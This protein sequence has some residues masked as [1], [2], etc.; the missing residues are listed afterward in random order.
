MILKPV[1]PDLTAYPDEFKT[2]LSNAMIFDS[3][4]SSN[5]RV[6]FIDKDGGYF[7]KSAEKGMLEN[8]VKMTRYF[9]NKGLSTNVISYVSRENDWL[10]TEKINGDDCIAAKYLDQPERLCDILAELLVRLHSTDFAGCPVKNHT[11]QYIARASNNYFSSNFDKSLFP[12]NWGYRSVDEA[13]QAV[14]KNKHLL[15]TDT[16]LHG[17]Y[18]LPNIILNDWKFGGFI[19]LVGSGVGDRHVDIFWAIWS[20]SFN[21]KTNIYRERFIDAYGRCNIDEDLLRVVAAIE[22]FG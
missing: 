7:L 20:L 3:S 2:M 4:C 19:D 16:L 15:K 21:L 13:W 17:D 5:A 18:C 22:V 11:N 9:H 14:E 1:I 8:E 12:D 6:I 10:L